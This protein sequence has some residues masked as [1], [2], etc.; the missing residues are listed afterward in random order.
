MARTNDDVD[1]DLLSIKSFISVDLDAAATTNE[2]NSQTPSKDERFS[3][4]NIAAQSHKKDRS[5]NS[6]VAISVSSDRGDMCETHL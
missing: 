6:P 3:T 1:N 2:N 5:S 4:K